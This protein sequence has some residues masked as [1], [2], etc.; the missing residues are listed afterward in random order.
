MQLNMLRKSHS[1][2]N[3]SVF[4]HLY[5]QHNFEAPPFGILGTKVE[6]HAMAKQRK[7]WESHTKTGY[8]LG[9]AWRHYRCHNIWVE[10]TKSTRIGQTVFFRHKYLTAPQVTPS[11]ALIRASDQMCEALTKADPH[12][13]ETRRAIDLLVKI[14]KRKD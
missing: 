14:F 12:S 2:P 4:N 9:P 11:D 7:T 6:I 10:D 5:G 8:Y 1:T 3:I 13:Q